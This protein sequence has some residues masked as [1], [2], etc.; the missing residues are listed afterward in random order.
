MQGKKVYCI[1]ETSNWVETTMGTRFPIFT[2]TRDP[3]SLR[4][5]LHEN[6]G[7]TLTTRL[8]PYFYLA[9]VCRMKQ[10]TRVETFHGVKNIATVEKS[11]VLKISFCEIVCV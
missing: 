6:K 3:F 5:I 11:Y 1:V 7:L 8:S 2:A 9:R 4:R 10:R